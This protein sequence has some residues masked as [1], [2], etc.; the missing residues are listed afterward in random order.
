MASID[1]FEKR[2]I[3]HIPC[4][5]VHPLPIFVPTPTNN[6]PIKIIKGDEVKL[7][8]TSSFLIVIKITC[9]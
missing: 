8:I 5:L 1:R 6:P 7:N 2:L 4:P 9:N 3:P